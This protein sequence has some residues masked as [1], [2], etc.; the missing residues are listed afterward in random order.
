MGFKAK[1]DY[2]SRYKATLDYLMSLQS[3][4][5]LFDGVTKQH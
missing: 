2:L 4:I 5:R 1:L 3:K